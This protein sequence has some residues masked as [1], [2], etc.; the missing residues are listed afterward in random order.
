MAPYDIIDPS[1]RS[2]VLPNAAIETL[3]TGFRWL[4]GPVWFADHDCLV[5]S[6][7]PNDRV[8][9][10]SETGGV[11]VFRSPCG[12]ENGHARDREGR[13]ISC[14]HRNRCVTRTE[15]DG[16]ITVLAS[17][18]QGRRLNAPNDVVVKSD[19][20][21]WFT[22]PLYGINTDYEGGRQVSEQ[23]PAVY[24][25][26][27]ARAELEVVAGDFEGPN[28]LCFSPDERVLYI[29][30]TG[31][32]FAADPVRHIRRAVL[33]EN[34]TRLGATMVFHEVVPGGADGLR[35]DEDG[36]V[37][38]SA[39]DGV[40]CLNPQGAL[41]GK[42]RTNTPVANLAF[43]GRQRSRLFLCA[44]QTLLG[45]YVNRRGAVRP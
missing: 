33:T 40:H 7:I 4:E 10:W 21:I 13:L 24:R 11:S 23:R 22:D 15:W 25:L 2:F 5:F 37:W 34:G 27:P 3:G 30:E 41:L 19:G 1:F 9:R 42:I 16:R 12:F 45:V 14:S 38:T 44:G 18:Y 36:N 43:G 31:Q 29:V 26:D 20:S 32:Q 6:D 8:L 39:A 35:C 17:H 28:G